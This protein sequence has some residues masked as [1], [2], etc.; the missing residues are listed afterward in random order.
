MKD[1]GTNNMPIDESDLKERLTWLVSLR[2]SGILGVLVVTHLALEL[3]AVAFSLLPMYQILGVASLSNYLYLW[4]LKLPGENLRRLTL[5]QIGVDQLILAFLVYFTGGRDSPYICLF[6]FHAVI[7]GIIL[8]WQY[9]AVFAGITIFLPAVMVCL[10]FLGVLPHYHIIKN[11]PMFTDNTVIMFYGMVFVCTIFLTAYFAA[12]LGRQLY[13]KSEEMLKLCNMSKKLRSSLRFNDV[14]GI[15]ECE[16][17]KLLKTSKS[18]YMQLNKEKRILSLKKPDGELHIPLSE[19]NSFTESVQRGVAM[20]LDHDNVKLDYE[21][22]VLDLMDAKRCMILPVMAAS[23]QL[24]SKYFQCVDTECAAFE[25]PAGKCWQISGTRCK[26]SIYGNYDDKLAACLTCEIFR[27]VGIY[28]LDVSQKKIPLPNIEADAVMRLLQTAG[29]SISN[30]L[31]HE[32]TMELSKTDGLTG[33]KNYR[34]FKDAFHAELLRSK[35]YQRGG[36]L[37][38]IDVDYFKNYNDTNGH[39]QGDVLLKKLAEL[40]L[41]NFKD[42]DIAARYGGEEFAV[43]LLE[44]KG[45]NEAVAVAERLKGLVEWCKFPNGE[46]QPG[47]KVTVSIGVSCCPD[48]GTTVEE[49]IQAADAALYCAKRGGRNRVVAAGNS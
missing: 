30:A 37:L 39:P 4:R 36:S 3:S 23:L 27:P 29:F 9:P 28:V 19:K 41:D 32:K 44:T 45:K 5:I 18:A 25:N 40:I 48:D 17:Q 24:C 15:V 26:G 10:E 13:N 20:I 1:V 6:L 31:L 22:K 35:R 42:T 49:L 8:P 34:A 16:L 46:L 21:M 14:I 2:W 33:L 38:M 12:Y 47:G 11:E 7:S 43:L